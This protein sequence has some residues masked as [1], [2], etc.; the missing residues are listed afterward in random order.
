MDVNTLHAALT[1]SGLARLLAPTGGLV[2]TA[3]REQARQTALELCLTVELV[4]RK[5]GSY[6]ESLDDL[7]PDLMAEVPSDLYG[8]TPA[9]RM[10]MLRREASASEDEP[11]EE[12][13]DSGPA[14]IIYSRGV[15]GL[16]D[17]GELPA[18][19]TGLRISITA[20]EK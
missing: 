17:G 15:N 3:D 13:A 11:E 10:L 5:R 8:S 9:E 12:Q 18:D 20:P 7:G 1:R 4:R 16:D 2:E 19:D 14:L 6:P